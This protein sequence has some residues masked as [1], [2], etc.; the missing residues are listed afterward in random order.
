MRS[1]AVAR[2]VAAPGAGG[3]DGSA[4]RRGAARCAMST[5]W[6]LW[7]LCLAL[8]AWGCGPSYGQRL[9][10]AEATSDVP[11]SFGADALARAVHIEVNR[12][13]A[14]HGLGQL[15][16]NPGL[17]PIAVGHSRD[18]ALRNFFD[19]IS[20]DGADPEAR[21]RRAGFRCRVPV[22]ARTF[23]TSGENIY[24]THRI[25]SWRIWS[26]G[27]KEPAQFHTL[28]GLAERIVVGWL[29][30]PAHRDNLLQPAWKTEAIGVWIEASGRIHVTQNFC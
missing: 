25:I 26:D 6:P 27:R 23:L 19:H 7:T 13:R 9:S 1:D 5:S 29:N 4:G 12:A 16:W 17:L 20:P 2:R 8:A 18:M 30:S 24:Q 22:D 28:A 21:Y 14:E 15:S 11:V 10:E 3:G